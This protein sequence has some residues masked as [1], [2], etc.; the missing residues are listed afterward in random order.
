[1]EFQAERLVFARR[2]RQLNQTELATRVG[3]AVRTIQRYERGKET[4][5]EDTLGRLARE[6]AF[7]PE[8]FFSP[9]ALPEIPEASLSFRAYSKLRARVR[10]NAVA[11][12]QLTVCIAEYLSELYE[13]PALT[14]P[15]LS[16]VAGRRPKDAARILRDEWKLGHGPIANVVHLLEAHGVRVF[17]L[18]EDVADVDAFCFWNSGDAFVVLNLLKSG[19][20]GRFDGCHELGHLVLH[21]HIDFRSKDVELHADIFA[22]EFLVPEDS[23]RSQL[24]SVITIDTVKKLKSYWKVSAMAMVKRLKDIGRLSDWVYR[25]MCMQLSK[26]GY[27]RAEKDGIEREASS[28]FADVFSPGAD[29]ISVNELARALRVRPSDISPLVFGMPHARGHLR[30]IRGGQAS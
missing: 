5:S 17:S 22:G 20:R 7:P 10:D 27:R 28:L 1:M 13:F 15:D 2:R 16:E 4:P 25:S 6:L 8:F 3:L 9:R 30:L 11:V 14:V 29:G 18:A 21:R 12:A 24:P 23:L 26:E 19:E